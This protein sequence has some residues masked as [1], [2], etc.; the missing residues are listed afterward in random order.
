MFSIETLCTVRDLLG[1]SSSKKAE[2]FIYYIIYFVFINLFAYF[3]MIYDRHLAKKGKRRIPE[4]VFFSLAIVGGGIGTLVALKKSKHK[5]NKKSFS[6]GIPI[7]TA[8]NVIVF[9]LLI[10]LLYR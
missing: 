5:K 7:I 2:A 10:F 4:N 9:L 6:F 3:A 1:L 8:L